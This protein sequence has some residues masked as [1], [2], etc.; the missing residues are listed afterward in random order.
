[1]KRII[2]TF[3]A[4]LALIAAVQSCDS[5]LDKAPLD[6][7]ADANYWTSESN[8]EVYANTFFNNFVGYGNGGGSGSYYFPTLNDNQA[9]ATF[10]DW[11]FINKIADNTDWSDPYVEIRRAN[12]MINRLGRMSLNETTTNHWLGV[13]RM[14]RALQYYWLVRQFGDVPLIDHELQV[15][16][17]DVIYAPRTDRDKVMDFV[18]E[19]L[20]F[21]CG[22]IKDVTN[23]T[24]WSRDL[25]NAI[26]AEVCLFEGTY[27]KYRMEKDG[28]KAPDSNRAKTFLK[29]A[30]TAAAAVMAKGYT[31]NKS[32]QGNYNSLD[33]AG[34]PEM[35]LYKHYFKDVFMHSL[36]DYTASSSKA[37]GMTKDAFNAYLF[38]D[39]LPK[40]ATKLNN[41]DISDKLTDKHIDVTG[42]LEVRDPRLAVAVDP[43][44]MTVPNPFKGRFNRSDDHAQTS[45]TG[46]GVY[47]YDT[48]ELAINYRT[49]TGKNYTDAPLYWLSV[50]YL[51]YAE[52]CA[53]L[54][55]CTQ[56]DLDISVNKLRDRVNMPHLTISPVA[57]PAN[58]MG[59][60]S[61]IWEIRRERRVELMYDNNFRFWD[62][63]R[64][65]QL[66]KL[67]T[68]KYPD[69]KLG[70]NVKNDPES[71]NSTD[72]TVNSDGYID[73]YPNNERKYDPMYYF[74]PVPTSEIAI[75]KDLTQNPGWD[76]KN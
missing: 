61:L 16:E 10:R 71:I 60:S 76:K 31:L 52:A 34:N 37:Y 25:A 8:V 44:L 59:V 14:M 72:I 55:S 2:Y 47:K 13:A 53:E 21:A 45:S 38:T 11:N 22:N 67:D 30:K 4:S 17:K 24:G 20:N 75:N 3:T 50:I 41:T 56:N 51:E 73:A 54:G 40:S 29:E 15:S 74:W 33:L 19:D 66:D 57:D 70:A 5:I 7:F 12:I 64:W 35:I 23:K 6:S 28:Q 65:H 43:V 58:N 69:I 32:Y 9:D 39:G 18:L 1:M 26:K 63:N 49:E 46:Y 68:Q 36:P 48:K 62:L 27:C 42:L